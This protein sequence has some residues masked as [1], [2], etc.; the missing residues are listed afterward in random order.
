MFPLLDTKTKFGENH[1]LK[2]FSLVLQ[3][4]LVKMDFRRPDFGIPLYFPFS[5]KLHPQ[6]R[7]MAGLI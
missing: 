5:S 7:S 1:F 3:K 4:Q 6:L 2:L